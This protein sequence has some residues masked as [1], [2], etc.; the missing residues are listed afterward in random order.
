[1][2]E[3]LK[4]DIRKHIFLIGDYLLPF[5]GYKDSKLVLE[6]QQEEFTQTLLNFQK[7]YYLVMRPMYNNVEKFIIRKNDIAIYRSNSYQDVR[8]FFIDITQNEIIQSKIDDIKTDF[9]F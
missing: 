9:L 8:S 5:I 7:S 3:K 4:N 1:M 6:L 2:T